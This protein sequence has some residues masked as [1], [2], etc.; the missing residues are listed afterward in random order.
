MLEAVKLFNIHGYNLIQENR[1]IVLRKHFPLESALTPDKELEK[2]D[3]RKMDD[4]I[5]NIGAG[6]ADRVRLPLEYMLKHEL[7]YS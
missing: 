1:N 3:D 5:R 7:L 6:L 2:E 4:L